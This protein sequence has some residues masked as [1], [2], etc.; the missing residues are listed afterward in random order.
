M[1]KL[2]I[3]AGL[4]TYRGGVRI[5]R[6]T[7]IDQQAEV[8]AVAAETLLLL[9]GIADTRDLQPGDGEVDVIIGVL[10]EISNNA[11]APALVRQVAEFAQSIGM[12]GEGVNMFLRIRRAE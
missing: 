11:G 5:A 1:T 12:I 10:D 6:L 8:P 9:V 7:P 3:Q 4:E 2:R